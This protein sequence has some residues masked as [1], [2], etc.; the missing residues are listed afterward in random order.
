MGKAPRKQLASKWARTAAPPVLLP[1]LSEFNPL[2]EVQYDPATH[3]GEKICA[4][5][6]NAE[7]LANDLINNNQIEELGEKLIDSYVE[8][9]KLKNDPADAEELAD[10]KEE[11]SKWAKR[12]INRGDVEKIKM[13]YINSAL[14]ICFKQIDMEKQ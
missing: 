10:E 1:A 8:E 5:K 7:N 12:M 9:F 6:T 3:E 2:V 13:E 14:R 4:V 11:A